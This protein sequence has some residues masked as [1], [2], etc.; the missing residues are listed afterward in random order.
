MLKSFFSSREP[1]DHRQFSDARTEPQILQSH[2]VVKCN[3]RCPRALTFEK[4]IL[5][6]SYVIISNFHKHTFKKNPKV[7]FHEPE[8]RGVG[9]D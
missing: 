1:R 4:F 6:L 7:F 5:F 8:C 3:M 9:A 2:Q